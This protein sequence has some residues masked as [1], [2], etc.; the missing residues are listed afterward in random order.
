MEQA[1]TIG[2]F[3]DQ[4]ADKIVATIGCS[5]QQGAQGVGHGMLSFWNEGNCKPCG[6][7]PQNKAAGGVRVWPRQGKVP[8]VLA[9]FKHGV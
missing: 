9:I 1:V 4:A 2:I 5:L 3:G 7:R 8:I 6:S